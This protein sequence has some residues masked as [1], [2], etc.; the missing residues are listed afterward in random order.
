V[1]GLFVQTDE[2]KEGG[3]A[4]AEKRLPDFGPYRA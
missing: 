4:F 1:L 2:A 3:A